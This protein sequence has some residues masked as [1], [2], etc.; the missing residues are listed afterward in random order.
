MNLAARSAGTGIADRAPEIILLTESQY[1]F[2]GDANLPPI[3]EGFVIVKI[4]GYPE[5]FL[6][7]FQIPCNKLPGPVNGLFLEVISDTEIAQHLKEGEVLAITHQ[8]YIGGAKTLLA[9]G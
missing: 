3:G 6:G 2:G 1:P 9:G 7:Q 8:I 5:P 4:D